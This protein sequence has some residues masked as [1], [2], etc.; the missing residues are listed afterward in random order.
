MAYFGDAFKKLS[1]KEGG[2]VND[3]DDAGGETYRGISRKYN[4]TW[5]GWTMID[6]YKKHYTVGSKE[7]KSK[8]DNDVQLQ[9]LVWQKYKVGYWDVFELD[10]FNSQ[11]VAE[12]LFDTNVNCGQVAAIKMAQRV[13]GLKETGRWNLDLLNKLIA[14][15]IIAII[16]LCVT[17][18][19]SI[20]R[21]S[22]EANS[23]NKSDTAIN[24]VRIDSI[25]LV[26]TERESIVYKLKE[27]EK[28]IKD[29]VI[30]LNDSATWELFKK[31]VSE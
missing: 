21:F 26:I 13:L 20:S 16:N 17:L 27:H 15:F 6:S 9:K 4:P 24:H 8:L 29:K 14:I 22:V 23:Y 31:L 11:R 5:Q 25:Q 2:Y 10:D 12:Q 7:F 28:D 30:S 1:I 3:K 19:L 18:Y